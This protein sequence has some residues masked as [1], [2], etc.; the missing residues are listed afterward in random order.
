MINLFTS[1]FRSDNA[2]RQNELDMCLNKNIACKE[3]DRIYLLCDQPTEVP[4]HPK[5][6]PIYIRHRP[7]YDVMF[8]FVNSYTGDQDY[9]VIANSD[10]YFDETLKLVNQYNPNYCL[11]LTR[12]EVEKTGI[13][14]LNRRD[15]Q[16]VWIF[17]G[18]ARDVKGDFGLGVPGCDN[19]IAFRFEQ[20][21]YKVINPS[22]TIKTYHLHQSGVRT[23]NVNV[24]VPQPYK[25]IEPSR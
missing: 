7:T 1:Y 22:R 6:T 24:K 2:F 21:G 5:I 23:Y 13:R 17:K 25:L 14:F 18:K 19:A 12:W 9:N 10:I 4:S 20:A 3:I 15:S 16:D 8:S 11:A